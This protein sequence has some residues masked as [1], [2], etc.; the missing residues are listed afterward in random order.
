MFFLFGL[1]VT[2]GS[3]ENIGSSGVVCIHTIALPDQKLLCIERPHQGIYPPNPFTGGALSTEIDISSG[4]AIFTPIPIL[5]NPFCAGHALRG[6]G[7]VFVAGGDNQTLP[8]GSVVNGRR[9]LRI[10]KPCQGQKCI[11]EW[12]ILPDMTSD[13]WY[14]TVLT[15]HE[16]SQLIIGG[17]TKNLDFEDLRPTDNNPTYEYY[18][19]RGAPKRLDI[20]DWAYPH[21]LYPPAFQLPSGGVFM[22][23]SNRSI[24]LDTNTDTVK[25]ID[26]MPAMDHS[27][28][29][30]PHTPTMVVMPMTIANN[31]TFELM[32]CGGSKLSTKE[33]SDMCITIRPD[34]PNPQWK[35]KQNM[36]NPRLMPDS[37]LMP[38]IVSIT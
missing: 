18:P 23:V 16:G 25:N 38:G 33:A 2:Q 12:T 17:S 27:P 32:M 36:P 13:R 28:W 7:T 10:F 1:A 4:K 31:F 14:P 11:G 15:L 22:V 19:S 21:N 20:L 34:D 8:D 26:D 30:Y 9:G 3:W 6:D 35:I 24:I 5:N 37:V 29:I